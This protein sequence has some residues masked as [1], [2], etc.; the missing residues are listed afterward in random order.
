VHWCGWML[1]GW[2]CRVLEEK[3]GAGAPE[4]F[5]VDCTEES[6]SA[7]AK[8]GADVDQKLWTKGAG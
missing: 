4:D 8:A 3:S 5:S 7:A 6:P 1:I 2:V